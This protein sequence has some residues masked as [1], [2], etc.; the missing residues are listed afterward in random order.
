MNQDILKRYDKVKWGQKY[1]KEDKRG[2]KYETMYLFGG[3]VF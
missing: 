2:L 1:E 3:E